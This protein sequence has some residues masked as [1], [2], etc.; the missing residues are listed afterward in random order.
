M[1]STHSRPKA[2]AQQWA[3]YR[4][5]CKFQHTA[6]RR[7][8][9]Y[10]TTSNPFSL[11]FQHTAARRRLMPDHH[12]L[13]PPEGFNTQP[14]EGGCTSV[15]DV[16]LSFFVSTHSRPKAAVRLLCLMRFCFS[17]FNTQPPEGG[18]VW[19]R[20]A[21]ADQLFQHTA[22]RRRLSPPRSPFSRLWGFNT[23]PPE[24]GWPSSPPTARHA[25]S[26]N[27]QPPEGGCHAPVLVHIPDRFQHTAAR[28]RLSLPAT[29]T[30]QQER[31]NTQPPEGGWGLVVKYLFTVSLFQHTAARRRLAESDV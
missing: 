5:Y 25:L 2:A 29:T 21:L 16:F 1:V 22:A 17:C 26:F 14:P 30:T 28:R 12:L 24:G 9:A 4:E 8:L 3:A 10:P 31:F 7:R 13:H 15:V 19:P 11:W 18:C 20:V 27:T 6:A 23:Q